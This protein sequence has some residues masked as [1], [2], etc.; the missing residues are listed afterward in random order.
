MDDGLKNIAKSIKE[1]SSEPI[2][3]NIDVVAAGLSSDIR[4]NIPPRLYHLIADMV[5]LIKKV[6]EE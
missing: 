6:D 4:E 5:S 1:R 3:D 2:S